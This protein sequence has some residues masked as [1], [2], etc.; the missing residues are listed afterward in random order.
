MSRPQLAHTVMLNDIT[1]FLMVGCEKFSHFQ[2]ILNP[3]SLQTNYLKIIFGLI[4]RKIGK[5]V[6]NILGGSA[7]G[8]N[9]IAYGKTTWAGIVV[10]RH[11]KCW[12]ALK[13]ML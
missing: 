9:S 1:Y 4:K 7:L 8:E 13:K 3:Q 2:N 6:A 10:T 12:F 5:Q 11:G